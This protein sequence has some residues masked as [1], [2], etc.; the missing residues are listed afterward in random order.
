MK[1]YNLTPSGMVIVCL[2]YRHYV[3]YLVN[4]SIKKDWHTMQAHS[5]LVLAIIYLAQQHVSPGV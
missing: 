1:I 5:S 2:S 4:K 3:S